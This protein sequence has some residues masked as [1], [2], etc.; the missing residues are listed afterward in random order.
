MLV[1]MHIYIERIINVVGGNYGYRAISTLLGKEEDNHTP[2]RHQ[3]IQEL[4]THKE[5]YTRLYGKK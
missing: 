2:V 4:R 1:F 3:L 5:S